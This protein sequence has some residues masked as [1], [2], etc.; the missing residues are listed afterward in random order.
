ML[1]EQ[2]WIILSFS[3]LG[4]IIFYSCMVYNFCLKKADT[5]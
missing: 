2:D 4:L 3:G 1:T 5:V